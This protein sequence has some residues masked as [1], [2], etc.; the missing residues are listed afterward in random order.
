MNK[1]KEFIK[2]LE[3]ALDLTKNGY[4]FNKI[5]FYVMMFCILG[6]F[7]IAGFSNDWSLE[8]QF[9]L[10]CPD[11]YEGLCSNPIYGTCDD[12]VCSLEFVSPGYEYGVKPSGF[13]VNFN[14]IV[15][16]V[17]LFFILLNH[18]WFNRDYKFYMFDEDKKENE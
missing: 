11:N 10:S 15:V 12:P 5:L 17:V 7:L 13:I 1:I 2:G 4:K 18:F 16:G 3:S 8:E 9:Y 6:L 14:F